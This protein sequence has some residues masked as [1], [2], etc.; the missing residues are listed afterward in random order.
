MLQPKD[1]LHLLDTCSI[2]YEYVE[3]SAVRTCEEADKLDIGI[4]GQAV[5]NIFL[6][7][8][9]GLNPTLVV[10]KSEQRLDLR[11]LSQTLG[12]KGLRFASPRRLMETLG[13]E[14]GAVSLLGLCN[15]VQR[16]TQVVIAEEVW[17]GDR[18]LCHPLVNTATLSIAVRDMARLLEHLEFTPILAAN[19]APTPDT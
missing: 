4:S 12:L 16:V 8:A 18:I 11:A 15:D 1:V 19:P 14:P 9:K 3:H 5:K 7:D 6:C 10:L 13:V 17:N 2:A